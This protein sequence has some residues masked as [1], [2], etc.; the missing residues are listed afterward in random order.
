[1]AY[2][3]PFLDD[4]GFLP[5]EKGLEPT[6]QALDSV[7]TSK[8]ITHLKNQLDSRKKSDKLAAA[9]EVAHLND[10]RLWPILKKNLFE[11][12]DSDIVSELLSAFINNPHPEAANELARFVFQEKRF[13]LRKKAI[14]VLSHFN[15]S[16]PASD[17]L[18]NLALTDPDPNIR[19]E[20]VF[21]LGEISDRA[22]SDTLK[23]ILVSD[24]NRE[25]RQMAVWALGRMR[26]DYGPIIRSLEEDTSSEVRREAAWILGRNQAEVA[27]E[28][29]ESA[30]KKETDQKVLEVILWSMAKIDPTSLSKADIVLEEDY[31][32]RIRAEYIWLLGRYGQK[33]EIKRIARTY[34]GSSIAVKRSLIWAMSQ[35][36]LV[37]SQEYLRHWYNLE[38]DKELKEKILWA[39]GESGREK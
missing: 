21:A 8:I 36:G 23:E 39:I 27:L 15:N 13:V 9:W 37:G 10:K 32:E 16:K 6:R 1:M 35:S 24:E 33:K 18:R 31:S 7:V 22:A 4:F 29:L 34:A 17:A 20:S 14:W 5:H 38:K 3:K 25:V 11:E 19:K 30:L 26:G 2:F 12:T 28:K